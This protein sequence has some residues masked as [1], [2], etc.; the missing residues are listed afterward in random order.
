MLSAY[1]YFFFFSLSLH[2]HTHVSSSKLFKVINTIDFNQGEKDVW[3]IKR[4]EWKSCSIWS[5]SDCLY[6]VRGLS[7]IEMFLI[8]YLSMVTSCIFSLPVSSI[9][10]PVQ[11]LNLLVVAFSNMHQTVSAYLNVHTFCFADVNKSARCVIQEV[12]E[13]FENRAHS[14]WIFKKLI[15]DYHLS[16]LH[17]SYFYRCF[18]NLF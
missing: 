4:L 17:N 16:T 15:I 13:V 11:F 10:Q 3:N 12:V 7:R 6:L 9:I 5:V 14:C 18:L 1:F 2:V 8:F